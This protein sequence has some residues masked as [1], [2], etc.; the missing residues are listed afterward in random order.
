MLY[1]SYSLLRKV[2]SAKRTGRQGGSELRL[3]VRSVIFFLVI[4]FI[5]F[6]GGALFQIF[7]PTKPYKL[8]LFISPTSMPERLRMPSVA[9]S[10]SDQVVRFN[11]E[12]KKR[13]SGA[14]PCYAPSFIVISRLASTKAPSS[15][16]I[17]SL[18]M[19][20]SHSSIPVSL[21]N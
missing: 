8:N 10:E 14:A 16:S 20:V 21:C 5:F 1:L 11:E 6:V 7:S 9:V 2:I 13:Q 12:T 18:I 19:R 17:L 4:S 15:I 3:K